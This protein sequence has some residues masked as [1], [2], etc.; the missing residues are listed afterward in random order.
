MQ[1]GILGDEC[2]VDGLMTDQNALLRQGSAASALSGPVSG[3]VPTIHMSLCN[4]FRNSLQKMPTIVTVDND[5][6]NVVLFSK[7]Q[8]VR[9]P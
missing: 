3:Q 2:T 9:I 8:C 1:V 7:L 4:Q 6:S 5:W